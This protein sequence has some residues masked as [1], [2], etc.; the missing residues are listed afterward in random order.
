MS[1]GSRLPKSD[2]AA[3]ADGSGLYADDIALPRMLHAKI[4]RSPH[5]HARI[6]AIDVSE[7]EKVPGVIATLLGAELPV[8]YGVIPWTQDENA[9]AVEKVRFVGDE[10][11]CVAALDE[12]TA[13]EALR[14]IRVDYEVLPALLTPEDALAHP[15][16]KVNERAK[17]GNVTKHVHLQ[18]GEVDAA[19]SAAA[20][21]VKEIAP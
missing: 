21:V 16:I 2:G 3:K 15:E 13:E 19:V 18:F 8:K 7:A 10:V 11:A 14:L 20:A 12:R 6:R 4:L 5:A 1:I 9:L 17:V